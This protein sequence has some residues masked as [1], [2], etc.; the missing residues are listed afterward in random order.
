MYGG[1]DQEDL[2]V[3]GYSDSDWAGNKESRKSTFGFIFMLNG[4]LVSSCS[5]RQPTV[6]LLSTKAEYI[7]LTLAAK[8]ATWLRL[9]LRKLGL[10]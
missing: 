10:L 6:A 7:A 3:K 4:G 8:E 1:L 2:L 9:L 5:K